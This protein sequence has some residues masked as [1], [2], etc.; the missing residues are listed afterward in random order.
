MWG[1]GVATWSKCRQDILFMSGKGVQYTNA[2]LY[3]NTN[4]LFRNYATFD[5]FIDA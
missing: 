2:Y 5:K 4:L 1:G 3:S